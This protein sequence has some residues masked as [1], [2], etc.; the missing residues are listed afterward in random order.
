MFNLWDLRHNA[1]TRHHPVTGAKFG[2]RT[3]TTAR[4]PFSDT[5]LDGFKRV[6]PAIT[7]GYHLAVFR[8]FRPARI[9]I[10]PPTRLLNYGYCLLTFRIIVKTRGG[11]PFLVG[12]SARN[13]PS[14]NL[15]CKKKL[16]PRHIRHLQDG[17]PTA[18][19][20]GTAFLV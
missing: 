14:K 7:S 2:H 11:V 17:P 1:R 12:A 8:A 5:I 10:N 3:T 4:S 16:P 18:Y 20:K 19:E 9:H 13:G 15:P 6:P